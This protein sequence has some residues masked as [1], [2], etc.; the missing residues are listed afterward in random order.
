MLLEMKILEKRKLYL[1]MHHFEKSTKGL[2][3]NI[4]DKFKEGTNKKKNLFLKEKEVIFNN[5][6]RKTFIY[7]LVKFIKISIIYVKFEKIW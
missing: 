1:L 4:N 7:F 5:E 2:E 3:K 6:L